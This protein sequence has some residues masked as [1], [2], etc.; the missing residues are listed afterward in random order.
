MTNQIA[1]Y[2]CT[3]QEGHMAEEPDGEWVKYD[4]LEKL[5]G[6]LDWVLQY[7]HADHRATILRKLEEC[8]IEGTRYPAHDMA[9]ALREIGAMIPSATGVTF[10]NDPPGAIVGALK[11]SLEPP[12]IRCPDCG[13]TPDIDVVVHWQHDCTRDAE[14]STES[15]AQ[16]RYE[17]ICGTCGQ[18]HHLDTYYNHNFVARVSLNR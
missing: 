17:T 15:T 9:Q 12:M 14:T 7:V 13:K 8:Q 10:E 18:E 4:E 2:G 5:R 3:C 11:H 16:F 6:I 1:R